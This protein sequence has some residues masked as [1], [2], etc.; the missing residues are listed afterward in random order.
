MIQTKL[1]LLE[2]S[3]IK[4]PTV[5]KWKL[6]TIRTIRDLIAQIDFN[7]EMV[8]VDNVEKLRDL[9]TS[10]KGNKLSEDEMKLVKELVII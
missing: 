3:V 5:I 10:L 7:T 4:S 8:P 6:K 9:L 1:L 2:Y